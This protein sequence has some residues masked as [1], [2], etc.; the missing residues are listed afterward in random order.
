MDLSAKA[1]NSAFSRRPSG[2]RLSA[3]Q[4]DRQGRISRSA[5][6]ALPPAEAIAFL[7]AHDEALGGVRLDIAVKSA[8]GFASVER[9]LMEQGAGSQ[10]A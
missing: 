5:L 10:P 1:V 6:A 9:A 4:A 7:N 2:V 3:E 8:E